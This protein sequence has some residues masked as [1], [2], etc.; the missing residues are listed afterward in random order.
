M[1]RVWLSM[2]TFE[3]FRFPEC[4]ENRTWE[5]LA[6]TLTSKTMSHGGLGKL[7]YKRF[8]D[9]ACFRNHL[10]LSVVAHAEGDMMCYVYDSDM[11]TESTRSRWYA[12]ALRSELQHCSVVKT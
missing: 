4:V 12:W 3:Q 10:C 1:Q 5:E 9:W 7:E 2:S 6:G 8:E 11:R